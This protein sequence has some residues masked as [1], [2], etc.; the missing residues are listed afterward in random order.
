MNSIS[1]GNKN[2][3]F[4]VY[5]SEPPAIGIADFRLK[6]KNNGIGIRFFYDTKKRSVLNDKANVCKKILVMHACTWAGLIERILVR[7]S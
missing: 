1:L 5:F 6:D 3:F 7:T 4:L 2:I